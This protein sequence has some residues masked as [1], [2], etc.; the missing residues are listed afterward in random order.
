[1]I[2]ITDMLER[3]LQ[4]AIALWES[5]PELVYPSS[6][7][8]VERLTRFLRKNENLSSA[9]KLNGQMVGA[10]LCGN[11]GRRGF[12][13]HIGVEPQF[14]KQGIATRMVEYSFEKLRKESIDT[15]FLFTND[16]NFGAQ[17]FWK[18]AGFEYAPHVMYQSRAI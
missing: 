8:T 12:F 18:A 13:Y 5:I 14:R 10:L 11:D 17:A 9:A 2:K 7:D 1:M 16:F 3:D 15:C 6:F 4:E